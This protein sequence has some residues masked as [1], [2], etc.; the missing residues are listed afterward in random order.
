MVKFLEHESLPCSVLYRWYS[1]INMM[2]LYPKCFRCSWSQVREMPLYHLIRARAQKKMGQLDDC[3]KTL[4]TA[5]NL[6]GVKKRCKYDPSN[7]WKLMSVSIIFVWWVKNQRNSFIMS[8]FAH[9]YFLSFL[10]IF[11]TIM[12]VHFVPSILPHSTVKFATLQT[13]K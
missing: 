1:N 9:F 6:S 13:L 3:V 10:T 8:K 4:Q 7:T 11:F 2:M 12:S 5:M